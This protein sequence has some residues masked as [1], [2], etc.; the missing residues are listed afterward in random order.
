MDGLVNAN[1]PLP[2]AI[3]MMAVGV[4]IGMVIMVKLAGKGGGGK[5]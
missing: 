4:V 1:I 2:W 5:S 3:A